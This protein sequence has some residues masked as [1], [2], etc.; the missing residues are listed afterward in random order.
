M[1]H[2]KDGCDPHEELAAGSEPTAAPS[3]DEHG[4]VAADALIHWIAALLR[5][6]ARVVDVRARRRHTARPVRAEAAAAVFALAARAAH[7]LAR[8]E[9]REGAVIARAELLPRHVE[10]RVAR[11]GGVLAAGRNRDG[12]PPEL[13]EEPLVAVVPVR[14]EEDP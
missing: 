6:A 1:G 11:V 12:R 8:V 13:A 5:R 10:R 7:G 2:S 4:A 14:V 9:R 3:L